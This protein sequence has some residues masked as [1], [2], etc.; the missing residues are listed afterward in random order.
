MSG[1]GPGPNQT[2]E[3]G[4]TAFGQWLPEAVHLGLTSEEKMDAALKRVYERRFRTGADD[5]EFLD[6]WADLGPDTIGCDA[7]TQ[8]AHAVAQVR[9]A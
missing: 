2:W 6:P 7:H 8:L 1:G 4:L 9:A 3:F 5:P